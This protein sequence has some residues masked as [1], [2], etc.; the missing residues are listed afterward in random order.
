[1]KPNGFAGRALFNP[2]LPDAL[3]FPSTRG[4]INYVLFGRHPAMNKGD[5]RGKRQGGQRAAYNEE[6]KH[7]HPAL[8]EAKDVAEVI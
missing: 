1:M 6:G 3:C 7:I 5:R 8:T 4:T 2:A